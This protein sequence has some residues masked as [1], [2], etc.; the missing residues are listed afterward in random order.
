ML[1]NSPEF[2]F[3]F[4]PAV[5]LL[6]HGLRVGGRPVAALWALLV[7]STFFYGWWNP[8]Y[9]ALIGLSIVGNLAVSGLIAAAPKGSVTRKAIVTSG[10]AANLLVLAYFKY[11]GFLLSIVTGI[12]GTESP[13]LHVALPLAISFFTFTQ[14]SYLLD[15]HAER[16]K[17]DNPLSYALFVVFFPH[18][19]A[20]PIVHHRELAE[21]FVPATHK[22]MDWNDFAVGMTLFAGGLFKKVAIAD[23]ASTF[24]GPVYL[25]ATLGRPIDFIGAWG[26]ALAYSFQL[27]FDFSGYSDM[28]LGLAL[29][30]GIR[31]PINFLSPYKAASLIDFWRRWHITLSQFLRD[32][33]Y[34]PLGGNRHGRAR[35]LFA[36][37]VTM[38]LGGLWHGAGW[39]FVLWGL[40]HG[41][42][43]IV[44][45]LWRVVAN[46]RAIRLPSIVGW[47]LT[48]LAVTVLW[49]VF[50]ASD[51]TAAGN[52]L[53]AMADPRHVLIPTAL[54]AHMGAFSDVF[55]YWGW[56][57]DDNRP[58]FSVQQMVFLSGCFFI[59]LALPNLYEFLAG[60]RPALETEKFAVKASR[61]MWRPSLAWLVLFAVMLSYASLGTMITA[62]E[63]LYFRF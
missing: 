28:A 7:A 26:G 33:L 48:F 17:V 25:N 16:T 24:V 37:T 11:I 6:F 60:F 61:M 27:Y 62:S 19:I 44:N 30:F 9:L 8:V 3:I 14:I 40:G 49:V 2:I 59:V 38:F 43:L 18:L 13:E 56:R 41:V 58:F 5:L 55:K 32:Y 34:V 42:L 36:V 63:F 39:T 29:L 22:P 23:Y 4:L 10:V 53:R 54:E 12:S 46:R 20:G 45:H 47:A 52:M 50:R 57:F 21:Q 15:V 35:E 51:L 1:F 31:L